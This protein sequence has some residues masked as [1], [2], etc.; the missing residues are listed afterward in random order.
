MKEQKDKDPLLSDDNLPNSKAYEIVRPEGPPD[1]V[2]FYSNTL[3]F[4]LF[5]FCCFF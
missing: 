2:L 3:L 5:L 1:Q 4:L